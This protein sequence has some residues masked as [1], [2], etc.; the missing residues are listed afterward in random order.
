MGWL[1][2]DHIAELVGSEQTLLDQTFG[3]G[4]YEID[5][6]DPDEAIIRTAALKVKLVY[7]RHRSSDVGTYISLFGVYAY[8]TGA[9][10]VP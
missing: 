1:S 4:Q 8:S 10:A 5:D 7:D 3:V 2:S 6:V 9:T